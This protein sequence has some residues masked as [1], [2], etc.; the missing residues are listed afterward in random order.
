MKKS[1][2]EMERDLAAAREALTAKVAALEGTKEYKKLCRE[3]H[4]ARTALNTASEKHRKVLMPY[5]TRIYDLEC[6]L[7]ARRKGTDIEVP[8]A[9]R[10]KMAEFTRGTTTKIVAI[11]WS[12][13]LTRCICQKKGRTEYL[14]RA[15]PSAYSPSEWYLV[16]T[17]KIPNRSY[18]FHAD[19]PAVIAK[20]E[21]R[22]PAET[23]RK[24]RQVLKGGKLT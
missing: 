16:D 5:H 2:V 21:G 10:E 19:N 23:G 9:L 22:L 1:T 6:A 20:V 3:Y 12:E 24:W 18:H 13:D 14:T 17:T 7:T 4:K 11:E 8:K 15:T